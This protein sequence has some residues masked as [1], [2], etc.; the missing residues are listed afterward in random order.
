MTNQHGKGTSIKVSAC[1][2]LEHVFGSN[3]DTHPVLMNGPAVHTITGNGV[4]AQLLA[5][6]MFTIP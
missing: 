4:M 6:R 3:T 2:N 1:I 5:A